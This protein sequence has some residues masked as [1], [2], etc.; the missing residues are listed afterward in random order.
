MQHEVDQEDTA[1]A[2]RILGVNQIGHESGNASICNG[3]TISWLQEVPGSLVWVPW[4]VNYRDVVILNEENEV[5]AVYNLTAHTLADSA[6]FATLRALL[7]EIA[8]G[9]SL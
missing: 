6:N 8:D 9:D 2:I 5:V 4:S 1:S 7:L 3:R